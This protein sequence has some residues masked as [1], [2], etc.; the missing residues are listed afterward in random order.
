ME[1]AMSYLRLAAV[2]CA[3]V[4]CVSLGHPQSIA[5]PSEVTPEAGGTPSQWAIAYGSGTLSGVVTPI[6]GGTGYYLYGTRTTLFKGQDIIF[7]QLDAS[8]KVT[9]AKEIDWETTN[10]DNLNVE[11]VATGFLVYGNV[12]TPGNTTQNELVWAKFGK[13]WNRVYAHGF[14]GLGT[15]EGGL[16]HD[17]SDGGL[18]F[19]GTLI[20]AAGTKFQCVDTL[21]FKTDPSG[22]MSWKN[23]LQYGCLDNAG[24]ML[25][26]SDGY[27]VAGLI[28][29]PFTK[30]HGVMVMKH[31]KTGAGIMWT[32]MYSIANP[33]VNLDMVG[34]VGSFKQLSDGNFLVVGLIQELNP[35]LGGNR[36]YM[37]KIDP[38]GGILWQNS[39]GSTAISMGAQSVIENTTD[40]TLLVNGSATNLPSGNLSIVAFTVNGSS[41]ALIKQKQI[42][43]SLDNNFGAILKSKSGDFYFSGWHST[44]ATDTNLKTIWGKLDPSTLAP[45]WAKTFSGGN[46][47]GLAIE[48][49]TGFFLTGTTT[50]Y[51]YNAANRNTFGMILDSTGNY[52]NCNISPIT[53][54]STEYPNIASTPAGLTLGQ[55]EFKSV[56]V[57]NVVAVRLPV[58][59]TTIKSLAICPAISSKSEGG[60]S[61]EEAD[62]AA[63]PNA[64]CAHPEPDA[65]ETIDRD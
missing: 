26:V 58:I 13:Q 63:D 19:T 32:N 12:Q 27:L 62:P 64:S 51:G 17:T 52:P 24:P 48:T 14:S 4:L 29:D 56:E 47:Y 15:I 3:V 57:G 5:E 6:T 23:V 35:T 46:A 44:A 34:T 16:F 7:A 10:T 30:I 39:Y 31:A 54:I 45:T 41:G 55:P 49:A 40:K 9:W 2:T 59:N 22:F 36:T 18:L 25:E 65:A 42:G 61:S 33:L 1:G 11:P 28:A 43:T 50:S 60:S 20:V 53:L 38:G 21:L 37:L 8:G